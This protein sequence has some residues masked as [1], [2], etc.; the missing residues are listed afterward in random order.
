M[1]TYGY[2]KNYG[3]IPETSRM[4]LDTLTGKIRT[5]S[6]CEHLRSLEL[7]DTEEHLHS[8]AEVA[9]AAQVSDA[10]VPWSIDYF[11]LKAGFLDLLPLSGSRLYMVIRVVAILCLVV[12]GRDVWS[13]LKS[14]TKPFNESNSKNARTLCIFSMSIPK[15]AKCS[16]MW[17]SSTASSSSKE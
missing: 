7:R 6:I 4:Y 3:A 13:E 10:C 12:T 8:G 14:Q 17:G 9:A 15:C 11:Q 2:R 1:K 16:A 5:T